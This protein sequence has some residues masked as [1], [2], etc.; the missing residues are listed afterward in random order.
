[1]P[2]HEEIQESQQEQPLGS[3]EKL[4]PP[5]SCQGRI[6][7]CLLVPGGADCSFYSTPASLRVQQTRQ[8]FPLS[9]Q[10]EILERCSG[11]SG[12]AAGITPGWNWAFLALWLLLGPPRGA[13]EPSWKG[14]TRSCFPRL[15]GRELEAVIPGILPQLEGNCSAEEI[16]KISFLP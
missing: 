15:G 2:W 10:K 8:R 16:G 3:G 9:L 11:C 5:P 13:E 14:P 7:W 1:M 12:S 4:P 6:W